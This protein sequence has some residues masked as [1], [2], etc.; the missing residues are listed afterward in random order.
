MAS[1]S[2]TENKLEE[3]I[4]LESPLKKLGQTFKNNIVSLAIV[5]LYV[6]YLAQSFIQLSP[7]GNTIEQIIYTSAIGLVVAFAIKDVLRNQGIESGLNL[8]MV[9]N[10]I[11]NHAML[12][13]KI[14]PYIIY[15]N[16]FCD[17]K[18][19]QLNENAK[20]RYLSNH[21]LNY[22]L[23]QKHYY[24]REEYRS[25]LSKSQVHAL[26]NVDKVHARGITFNLLISGTSTSGGSGK[27]SSLSTY[28]TSRK[29]T[30]AFTAILTSLIFG[31]FMPVGNA[32]FNLGDFIW[33]LI[34]ITI[35]LFFGICEYASSKSWVKNQYV[36]TVKIIEKYLTECMDMIHN[37]AQWVI[38]FEKDNMLDKDEK[39]NKDTQIEMKGEH[40]N[41]TIKASIGE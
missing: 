30:T 37:K 18:N 33:K 29:I 14:D 27:L 5:V 1:N 3:E 16:A 9:S 2:V 40:V 4:I 38:D 13:S 28:K 11:K 10:E 19:E 34:Q 23:Y 39:E 31:L 41:E 8:P 6:I 12:V 24:E 15:I 22:S 36:G 35:W 25:K 32:G 21:G 26:K 17:Y 7:T 20:R